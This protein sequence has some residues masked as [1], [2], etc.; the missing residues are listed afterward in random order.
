MSGVTC[1]EVQAS[2]AEFV[3]GLGDGAERAEVAAHLAACPTCRRHLEGLTAAADALLLAGPVVEPPAGF[4]E[5]VSQA[6]AVP[7]L[8][9]PRRGSRWALAAA[10]LVLAVFGIGVVVGHQ[11]GGGGSQRAVRSASMR[12]PD[13]RTVGRVSLS[14]EPDTV[15][16][17]VP[18]WRPSSEVRRHAQAEPYRLRLEWRSGRSELVGPVQLADG[19]GSWGTVL[20]A[21]TGDVRRVALVDGQGT[22]YCAGTLG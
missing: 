15:Y 21:N 1:G 16:V 19:D 17:A 11:T 7:V 12:T 5:R 9:R 3:L 4:E 10:A 14:T 22:E 18:G 13:G 2:A 20:A 6:I 8:G